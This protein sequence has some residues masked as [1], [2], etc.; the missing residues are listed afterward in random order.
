MGLMRGGA[1]GQH[2]DLPEVGVEDGRSTTLPTV[3][4]FAGFTG[5]TLR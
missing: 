2:G 3:W 4:P 1:V 5:L